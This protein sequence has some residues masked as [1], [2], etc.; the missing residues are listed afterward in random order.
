MS[1]DDELVKILRA[2]SVADERGTP[3]DNESLA[4][5]LRWDLE[6]VAAALDTAKQQSLV[7]GVRSG[8]K[9]SPWFT[10]LEVTVQGK[11]LLRD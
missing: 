9:P 10:D 7:W 5:K 11:R 8:R 3:L 4:V 6:R 2:I 1:T